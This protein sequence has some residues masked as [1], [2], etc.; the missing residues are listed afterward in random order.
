[1]GLKKP[2][3][4][5][6]K[7]PLRQRQK[8]LF[9]YCTTAW[10]LR[11]SWGHCFWFDFMQWRRGIKPRLQSQHFLPLF[12]RPRGNYRH[13]S[14]LTPWDLPVSCEKSPHPLFSSLKQWSMNLTYL[15]CHRAVSC[16]SLLSSAPPVLCEGREGSTWQVPLW[17]RTQLRWPMRRTRSCGCGGTRG[18]TKRRFSGRSEKAGAPQQEPVLQWQNTVFPHSGHLPLPRGREDTRYKLTKNKRHEIL[19]HM[20]CSIENNALQ[21]C[22]IETIVSWD[23]FRRQSVLGH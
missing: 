4:Q 17:Q 16:R 7:H 3:S 11:Q 9:N 14:N 18:K 1:M 19:F 8:S 21:K 10:E 6:S 22:F 23:H 13:S 5:L 12:Q 2:N 15:W 20:W